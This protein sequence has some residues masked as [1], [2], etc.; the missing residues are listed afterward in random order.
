MRQF[1][2]II[3]TGL[4]NIFVRICWYFNKM[5]I[6]H[7]IVIELLFITKDDNDTSCICIGTHSNSPKCSAIIHR[8]PLTITDNKGCVN[9]IKDFRLTCALQ[10]YT[11][12][13]IWFKFTYMQQ[14]RER[15]QDSNIN[16]PTPTNLNT[17]ALTLTRLFVL[18]LTLEVNYF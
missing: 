16:F 7:D 2:G 6:K 4:I 3:I 1:D 18:P 13:L 11:V 10:S 17:L 5:Y 12:Y 9:R 15:K 8:P 14:R